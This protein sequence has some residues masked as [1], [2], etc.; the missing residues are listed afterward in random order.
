[1]CFLEAR[2]LPVEEA[3]SS[4]TAA[5][6][7]STEHVGDSSSKPQE[8]PSCD[9]HLVDLRCHRV[10]LLDGSFCLLQVRHG[11]SL[12]AKSAVDRSAGERQ[13]DRVN[14]ELTKEERRIARRVDNALAAR[15]DLEFHKK[16]M[17]WPVGAYV[18]GATV[19]GLFAYWALA[20]YML[21]IA[22][23]ALVIQLRAY[24]DYRMALDYFE[25]REAEA[26]DLIMQ[27]ERD[28]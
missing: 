7:S 15:R 14:L 25:Q 27:E 5:I 26:L 24:M 11:S 3:S 13:N 2:E 17:W 10:E 23:P 8:R 18:T 6:A 21:I 28:A 22:A 16:L 19:V 9:E 20:P 1:M 12:H 4:R